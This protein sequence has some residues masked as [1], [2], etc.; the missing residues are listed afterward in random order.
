MSWTDSTTVKKHLLSA[1]TSD[2]DDCIAAAITEAEDTILARLKPEYTG[3]S[4]DQ[5]LKTGATFLALSIVCR[6]IAAKALSDSGLLSDTRA[7]VWKRM[8]D[9]YKTESNLCSETLPGPAPD[10]SSGQEGE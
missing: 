8:A 10:H 7:D 4:L 1:A 2:V 5:G 6:A 9:D 3:T